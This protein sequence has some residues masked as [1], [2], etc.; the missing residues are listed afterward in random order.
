MMI[1]SQVNRRLRI[2]LAIGAALT[3]AACQKPGLDFSDHDADLA[4]QTLEAAPAHGFAAERFHIQRLKALL[5]S[6]NGGDRAEGARELKAAL[7]DYARA[8]HGLTIPA[9]AFPKDWGLKPAPYDAEGG[10]NAA[11]KAGSLQA[12][13]EHQPPPLPAYQALQKAYVAY[14]KIPAAGGWPAVAADALA[15]DAPPPD[16]AALRL[17]L[18]YEDPQLTA[19][20]AD[21]LPDAGLVAAVQRFQWAHGLQVTGQLDT[22]TLAALNTPAESYAAQI[23]ANLERLRWLPRQEPP[24]RIDVNT[25][26]AV[27]DYYVDGRLASHMLAASGKPGDDETPMLASAI[28]SIVFNP[29]WNVPQEIAQDEILPKGADYLERKG[30]VW[31]NRRLVQQ[32][33]PDAALGVVK[34][35]FANPYAVYL[36][37]TPAKAAFAQAQ[38]AVSHGCVRLAQAIDLAKILLSNEPDWPAGRVDQTIASGDTVHVRLSRPVPVRLLYLTAF[39]D[40][41][42]LGFRSDLYGWDAQLL[43]LLDHPPP[44][45]KPGRKA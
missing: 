34:F 44:A 23:R 17:R 31:K 10:L 16:F 37:D 33:G 4:L 42:R 24:T 2:V 14:Q 22:G 1:L 19:T 13:L 3:L 26:A 11:L 45:R 8:Q 43:Q 18:A 41:D 12:W 36:H 21:Q 30:F 15:P 29:P 40:G 9:Q 28:D 25:A 27:M 38:R 35:E 7:V 6:G 20:P 39:S 5:H 32:P